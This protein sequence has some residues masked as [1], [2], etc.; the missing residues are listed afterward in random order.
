MT[1]F[2][3]DGSFESASGGLG[4]L[5]YPRKRASIRALG[6]SAKCHVWTAPSWQELSSRK[7]HWS[8]QPCVRP[9]MRAFAS[10]YFILTL[11]RFLRLN[12]STKAELP[13]TQV[14]PANLTSGGT[15]SSPR[16]RIRDGRAPG[17]RHHSLRTMRRHQAEQRRHPLGS[18]C[19]GRRAARALLGCR[20]RCGLHDCALRDNALGREPP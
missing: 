13:S 18:V 2:S 5:P 14:F 19:S 6:M 11:L 16:S 1:G 17:G 9:H 4:C 8:V 15:E 7:Q 3:R 10:S 20:L 12:R